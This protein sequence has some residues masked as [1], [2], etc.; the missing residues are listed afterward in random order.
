MKLKIYV[1]HGRK[2]PA[3]L[4]EFDEWNG[5]QPVP[6]KGE[7]V[8]LDGAFYLVLGKELNLKHEKDRRGKT[9][10]WVGSTILLLEPI[11]VPAR[12]HYAFEPSSIRRLLKCSSGDCSQ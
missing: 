9:S 10:V 8:K 11:K 1:K 6:E 2:G 12:K 7:T 3:L 4:V 5:L